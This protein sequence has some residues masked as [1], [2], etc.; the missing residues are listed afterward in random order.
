MTVECHCHWN[1]TTPHNY[2]NEFTDFTRVT[3][4]CLL[5]TYIQQINLGSVCPDL[6]RHFGMHKLQVYVREAVGS[7]SRTHTF[8]LCI[9]KCL[10]RSGQTGKKKDSKF[11]DSGFSMCLKAIGCA[12]PTMLHFPSDSIKSI[13]CSQVLKI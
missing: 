7:G 9:P 8:I 13:S 5:Y 10:P 6:C 3:L 2:E 11:K 4:C 12:F 1:V